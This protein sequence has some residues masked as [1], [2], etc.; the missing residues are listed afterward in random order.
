MFSVKKI[1]EEFEFNFLDK[2]QENKIYER[3]LLTMGEGRC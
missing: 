2:R 1:V 3:M